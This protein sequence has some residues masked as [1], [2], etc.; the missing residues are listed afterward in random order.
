MIP[1][2]TNRPRKRWGIYVHMIP[3]HTNRPRKRWGIYLP[4]VEPLRRRYATAARHDFS[5]RSWKKPHASRSWSRRQG[6]MSR[7][8]NSVAAALV[9]IQH[10]HRNECRCAPHS[11]TNHTPP[12][13]Q[14]LSH[15]CSRKG[16]L[17]TQRNVSCMA[18][19][20]HK[21]LYW[22]DK[23]ILATWASNITYILLLLHS[24][25]WNTQG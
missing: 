17:Q 15:R 20:K 23:P 3:Y 9:A 22:S 13:A 24:E 18:I 5:A 12:P 10:R 14:S 25:Y 16:F 11:P 8:V 19:D 4:V 2:L 7:M 21:A 1:Y 6:G